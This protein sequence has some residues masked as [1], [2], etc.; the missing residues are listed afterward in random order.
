MPVKSPQE[1]LGVVKQALVEAQTA[2]AAAL[3][4]LT[5]SEI[6]ELTTNL[7]PVLAGKNSVGHTLNDRA[8]GRRLC[9]LMEK[10]DRA[11][12]VDAAEALVPLTDP[13]L[14]EQLKNCPKTATC[15]WRA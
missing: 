6:R 11:A 1:A 8:T 12:L 5:K 4:P 10:M 9:D 13:K 15:P 3:A 2:Y 14:L 7:Y